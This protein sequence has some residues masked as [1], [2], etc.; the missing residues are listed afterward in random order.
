MQLAQDGQLHVYWTYISTGEADEAMAGL[1]F[2]PV[3][4][5]QQAELQWIALDFVQ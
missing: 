3:N 2:D 4:A 5:P 1:R